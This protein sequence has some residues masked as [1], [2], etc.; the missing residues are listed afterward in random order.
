[1]KNLAEK[2][3]HFSGTPFILRRLFIVIIES[4]SLIVHPFTFPIRLTA[5][6]IAGHL[7][8]SLLGSS[9]QLINNLFNFHYYNYLAITFINFRN[10]S[11]NFINSL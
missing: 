4:I 11:F 10:F 9:G 7:L 3:F 1:M 8:L 6:I 2:L 5:N